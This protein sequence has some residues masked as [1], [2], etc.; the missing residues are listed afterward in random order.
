[1][2]LV[3]L[4]MVVGLSHNDQRVIADDHGEDDGLPVPAGQPVPTEET[5]PVMVDAS[6][7]RA[8]YPRKAQRDG[9]PRVGTRLTFDNGSGM[10]VTETFEEVAA[11]FG[12]LN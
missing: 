7:I 11:K 10:A 8:F 1:M 4:T 6:K 12:R 5:S 3:Q 2:R 9:S